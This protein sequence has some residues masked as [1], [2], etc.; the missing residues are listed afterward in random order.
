MAFRDANRRR[1]S[2]SPGHQGSARDL[3][4]I[5]ESGTPVDQGRACTGRSLCR[6]VLLA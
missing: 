5:S 1:R 2:P 3:T 4:R 6:A